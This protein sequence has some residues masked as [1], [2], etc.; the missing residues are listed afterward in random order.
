MPRWIVNPIMKGKGSEMV[1]DDQNKAES[2]ENYF[3]PVFTQ[4]SL[5]DEE[6]NPNTKSTDRLLT[7]KFSRDHVLEALSTL[8]MKKSTGPDELHSQILKQ[9]VQYIGVPLTVIFNISL[10]QD[11]L[12]TNWKDAIVTLIHKT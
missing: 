9:I 1:D 2:M 3:G 7:V 4:V 10:E 6:L 8:E 11:V 5:L 12:P